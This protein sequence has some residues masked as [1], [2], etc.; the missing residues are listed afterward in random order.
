MAAVA[1]GPA[2]GGK[3]GKGGR[4]RG[5][6]GGGGGKHRGRYA[7]K[8]EVTSYEYSVYQK[9]MVG[10]RGAFASCPSCYSPRTTAPRDTVANAPHRGAHFYM[11]LLSYSAVFWHTLRSCAASAAHELASKLQQLQRCEPLQHGKNCACGDIAKLNESI[12]AA[13]G[14]RL[15]LVHAC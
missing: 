9:K 15:T 11:W 5:G 12:D 4:A 8:P 2:G 7:T 13:E 3:S 6:G 1:S 10:Q 14:R